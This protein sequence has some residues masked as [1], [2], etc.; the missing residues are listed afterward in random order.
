MHLKHAMFHLRLLIQDNPSFIALAVSCGLAAFFI[1]MII[2]PR[3][4][5][6]ARRRLRGRSRDAR[7]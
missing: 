3:Y 5:R 6:R 2:F 1:G 4:L 7:A